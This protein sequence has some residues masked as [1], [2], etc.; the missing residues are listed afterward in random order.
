M[1]EVCA[2]ETDAASVA[3]WIFSC[4]VLD[5]LTFGN[6]EFDSS[7]EMGRTEDYISY[8]RVA[9]VWKGIE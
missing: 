3:A 4:I 1:L 5:V 2:C 7:S 6:K 8:S 9:T